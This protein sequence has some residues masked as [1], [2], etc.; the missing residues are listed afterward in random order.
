MG[1]LTCCLYRPRFYSFLLAH[2]T[3]VLC[4]V[5]VA[6]M[7]FVAQYLQSWSYGC[8][9]VCSFFLLCHV[10]TSSSFVIAGFRRAY[11]RVIFQHNRIYWL[12]VSSLSCASSPEISWF[13][14][15]CK[16]L[17]IRFEQTLVV[18]VG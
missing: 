9:I 1:Y 16:W 15:T 5:F 14:K 8:E 6:A 13:F 18:S 12:Y 4:L 3:P 10:C 11:P 2:S 17:I 7:V